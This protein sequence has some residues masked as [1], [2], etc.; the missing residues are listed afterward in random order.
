MQKELA[1]HTDKTI[2]LDSTEAALYLLYIF[3]HIWVGQSRKTLYA[4]CF[5]LSALFSLHLFSDTTEDAA[6]KAAHQ[7]CSLHP[8][9]D[10]FSNPGCYRSILK[11]PQPHKRS[12]LFRAKGQTHRPAVSQTD[13]H[14]LVPPA[15]VTLEGE[16]LKSSNWAFPTSHCRV[17]QEPDP[18][19][20]R[21]RLPG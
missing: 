21:W 16:R 20:L 10:Y 18:Q 14:A 5:H 3:K 7:P 12:L 13:P 8:H 2:S 9:W 19:R 15:A 6:P 11:A 1:V 17:L 4:E